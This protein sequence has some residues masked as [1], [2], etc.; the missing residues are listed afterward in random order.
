MTHKQGNR[1]WCEALGRGEVCG[2]GECIFSEIS[3]WLSVSSIF[4]IWSLT[5]QLQDGVWPLRLQQ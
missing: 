1:G 4:N 3:R 2:A 5:E